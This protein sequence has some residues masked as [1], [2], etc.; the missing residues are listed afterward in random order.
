M[1]RLLWVAAFFVSENAFA[2][3]AEPRPMVEWVAP[4]LPTNTPQTPEQAEE[5]KKSGRKLP[6][7]EVLQPA[8][9]P[10]LPHYRP[11]KEKLT[12]TFKGGAS[13]V[14]I[15]LV[16]SWIKAFK[17]H[18][19]KVDLSVSPPYAGSLG[20]VELV[21]GNL[22]FV[23]VSRELKPEDRK[24]FKAKFGYDPM[25]VPV[26][27]GSY[28]HFG[29]LDAIAFFVHKDNPLEMLTFDQ[30][31]SIYS[32]TRHRGGKPIT[33]WGELGL[34]G[35]WADKPVKGYGIK[36]W[37][38]FE[39]FVRQRI[40]STADKRGEWRE[41]IGFEKVVFPM[42][43]HVAGDRYGIG[44]S[45]VAYIDQG[46]RVLPLVARAGEAPVAPSYE[47]VALAT[48]PLSRLTF[49]NVNKHPD[50][51]LSPVLEELLRFVLSKEGQQIVLDQGIYLPLRAVQSEK[52]RALLGG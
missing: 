2:Q 26:S 25:S 48:Y 21:K 39:E 47:N 17:I 27:G 31:D 9:D 30:I 14:L 10:Q 19:P 13:D 29:A 28:R 18:H 20:A 44:Y 33:K 35:E 4:A 49:F 52:S 32:A 50:K 34:T 5:G 40:L 16:Q 41:D 46:V 24:D 8:L 7:P 3:P 36:P 43:K 38:G 51:P 12:G 22:D 1:K 6:A 11:R 42:A 15:A 23:F 37:N 45:G